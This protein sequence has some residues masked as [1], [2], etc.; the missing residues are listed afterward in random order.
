[1]SSTTEE[2]AARAGAFP[3][4]TVSARCVLT[5]EQVAKYNSEGY[6][7]I[8]NWATKDQLQALSAGAERIVDN[9]D[10]DAHRS[11][12]TTTKQ[13]KVADDYMMESGDKVR[14]FF[15]TDAFKPD[16][17]LAFP[18]NKT[19]NKIG[20]ALHEHD[21]VFVAY[22]QAAP[23]KSLCASLGYEK[24]LLAQ[25]M[26]IFKQPH[27]GGQVGAHQDS[28]FLYT[29]PESCLGLWI[30]L[31]D[32]TPENGCMYAIPGSHLKG[33]GPEQK[34]LRTRYRLKTVTVPVDAEGKELSEEAIAA[35][36]VPAG[37]AEVRKTY[38]DPPM[39][40]TGLKMEGGVCLDVPAGTLVLLHGALVHYSFANKSEKQ[41]HAYTLHVVEGAEGTKW[42]ED[43]WMVRDTP[44]PA[45]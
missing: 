18:K 42:A 13:E 44:F 26:F 34:G 23:F 7:V 35:G 5:P 33:D 29:T 30:A 19:I 25:S 22:S 21:P 2:L 45:L 37:T 40:E 24:P 28:S 8:P 12:F 4:E 41:R 9:F 36:A 32:A 14:C 6:L 11:I 27:I 17:T 38:F 15:E 31:D 3:V 20:H 39:N 43:N 16:G 1:M 10:A